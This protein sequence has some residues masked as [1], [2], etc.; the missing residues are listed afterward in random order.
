MPN[1]SHRSPASNEIV[2]NLGQWEASKGTSYTPAGWSQLYRMLPVGGTS[3]VRLY[4]EEPTCWPRQPIGLR[5]LRPRPCICR[6]IAQ[7]SPLAV[8]ILERLNRACQLR[9]GHL[10]SRSGYTTIRI[11]HIHRLKP[12]AFWRHVEFEFDHPQRRRVQFQPRC[13]N[14]P[15]TVAQSVGTVRQGIS[16]AE[17]LRESFAQ[18]SIAGPRAE[19]QWTTAA[20]PSP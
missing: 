9:H 17:N 18:C 2:T 19:P 1:F 20:V 8:V 14:G 3:C 13:G 12:L 11:D 15:S 16:T 7:P 10:C 4:E 5:C 6:R